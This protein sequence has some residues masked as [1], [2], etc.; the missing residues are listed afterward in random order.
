MMRLPLAI[1]AQHRE[2]EKNRR[3]K[4]A[5]I[6]PEFNLPGSKLTRDEA[7]YLWEIRRMRELLR[8]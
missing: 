5:D 6:Q 7:S 4:P 3:Q 1:I 2:A 8:P